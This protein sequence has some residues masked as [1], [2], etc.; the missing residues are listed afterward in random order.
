MLHSKVYYMEL[1]GG[2]AV[3]F[4]GSHNATAFA[5]TGLNGEAAVMLEGPVE[6]PEFDE[7]RRHIEEARQQAV[8]YSSGLKEA[9]AWWTREFIEGLRVE[10]RLPNDWKTVRTI[11]LFASAAKQ[12]RPK[13]GDNLY[14]E[15]PAGIE[16]IESLKTEAH[17]F[18]FDVL[19]ADPWAALYGASSAV[20]RYKCKTLGV[21]NRQGNLEI[22]TNW[23]ID[24]PS[25]PVLRAVPSGKYRPSPP[26]GM[27]QV[28]AD[29]ETANLEPIEY[30]FERERQGWDPVFSSTDFLE[31]T[32]EI[33][34][35]SALAEAKGPRHNLDW[36]LVTG[37]APRLG[38]AK[39]KDEVALSRAAP[40][41]GSFVLV[42]LRRRRTDQYLPQATE[43]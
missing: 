22:T 6:S 32:K 34:D 23:R 21:E 5:L 3:A 26:S 25:R 40:D 29:V 9:Y 31:P 24:G 12:D 18:L 41:S 7:V 15:I 43:D 20:A 8:Q 13:A 38:I 28:R 27:Q 1:P 42:S 16:Q 10:V 11:V 39:E 4:I 30:L 37:L 2:H 35:L 17:L 33:V 36:R 19:P 14:F